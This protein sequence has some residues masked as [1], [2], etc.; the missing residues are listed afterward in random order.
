MIKYRQALEAMWVLAREPFEF[1]ALNKMTDAVSL[2]GPTQ[3]W[4]R[5]LLA[6]KPAEQLAY[7]RE[8]T[9]RPIDVEYLT[10][11]PENT[12]G[13]QYAA[14]CE[15]NGITPGGHVAAVPQLVDT[16]AKDWV[17]HRFFKIHDV[18]HV[19][20]GFGA[21]VPGEMGLQM[22]DALNLRE[23]YGIG[24]ILSTPYMMLFYG[25]PVRMIRQ[26]IRG[27]RIAASGQNLFFAPLEDMWEWDLE[28]VRGHLGI[29]LR[30]AGQH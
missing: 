30:L 1:V 10:G 18:L 5:R 11:L 24:A 27:A 12:L 20:G 25:Q 17:T 4:Y 13:Y 6:D 14:F 29:D 21:D 7:L 9:R 28:A 15:A 8:L 16:F 22:F 26:I 23:P 3:W 2:S 19:V